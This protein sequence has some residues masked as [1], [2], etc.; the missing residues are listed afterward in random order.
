MNMREAVDNSRNR[1]IWRSL[2]EA[3]SSAYAWREEKMEWKWT[4]YAEQT[5]TVYKIDIVYIAL[6]LC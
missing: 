4:L 5:P 3:S 1:K 2:V 6:F